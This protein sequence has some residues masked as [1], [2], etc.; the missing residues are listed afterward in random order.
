MIRT[1]SAGGIVIGPQNQVLVIKQFGNDVSYS[2][3]KGHLESGEDPL[4]AARREI[5]EEGGISDLKLIKTL[6][7]YERPNLFNP[8]EIKTIFMFLFQTSQIELSTQDPDKDTQPFWSEIDEV[9]NLLTHPK[10]REFFL[11]YLAE[12]KSF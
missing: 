4:T 3:P 10:D 1:R 11:T 2:L 12:I 8:D 7:S 6:G 9:E 5:Q